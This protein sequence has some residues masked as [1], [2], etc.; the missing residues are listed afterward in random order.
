MAEQPTLFMEFHGTPAGVAEQAETVGELAA[1]NNG[2]AFEWTT[3]PEERNRLWAARHNYYYGLKAMLPGRRG[4]A[5]DACVPI[6][7]LAECIDETERDLADASIFFAIVGHVG[8][9]NFHV[10]LM[11]DPDDRTE[12]TEAMR[13]ADRLTERTLRM[14]GT[15]SGEHGVGIGKKKFMAREHGTD[16]WE[17]MAAIKRTFDPSGILN[18]GK[19]LP[20]N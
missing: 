15:I 19:M 3:K 14:G 20:G 18:P 10:S 17:L 7:R 8:D 4:F 11:I 5:T 2:S 1:A 13:L 12:I 9:G 16:A 6:S